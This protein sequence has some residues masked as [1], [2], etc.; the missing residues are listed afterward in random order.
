M[1][2]SVKY[3]F[4]RLIRCSHGRPLHKAG[5][6]WSEIAVWINNTAVYGNICSQ[7][8]IVACIST[9][10]LL[11]KPVEVCNAVYLI[12]A[13]NRFCRLISTAIIAYS[14][15]FAKIMIFSFGFGRIVWEGHTAC[16]CINLRTADYGELVWIDCLS[17]DNT[18]LVAVKQVCYLAVCKFIRRLS[19]YTCRCAAVIADCVAWIN[20]FVKI[21]VLYTCCVRTVTAHAAC[22]AWI[23]AYCA[24]AEAGDDFAVV[25]IIAAYTAYIAITAYR[26]CVIAVIDSSVYIIAAYTAGSFFCTYQAGVITFG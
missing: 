8:S 15:S 7:Y 16:C 23:T 26:A 4:I 24:N 3:T 21:T 2:L 20:G 10:Y 25:R 1:S 19:K 22:I 6:I 18:A 17:P 5:R 9:V 14:V 11:S 12:Y 13:V